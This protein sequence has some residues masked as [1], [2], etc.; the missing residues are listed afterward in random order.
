MNLIYQAGFTLAFV[1]FGFLLLYY[2][3]KKKKI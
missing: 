1:L 3:Y 2:L